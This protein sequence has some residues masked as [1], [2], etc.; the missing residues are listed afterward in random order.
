MNGD[1]DLGEDITMKGD[2]FHFAQNIQLSAEPEAAAAVKAD[3]PPPEKVHTLDPKIAKAHT[4][5]YNAKSLVGV[6]Q[7]LRTAFYAQYDRQN[8]LWR[9]DDAL[10]ATESADVP[11]IHPYNYNPWVYKF[12][13]DAMGPHS[14]HI[15]DDPEDSR[16]KSKEELA[17]SPEAIAKAEKAAAEEKKLKDDKIGMKN[18]AEAKQTAEQEKK[19]DAE[20]LEGA[21][22]KADIAE[23][24]EKVSKKEEKKAEL[25]MTNY[26]DKFYNA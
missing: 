17:N 13:R 1:E 9:T 22:K 4:T 10:V 23:E 11:Q 7:D 5:F 25:L 14:Q 18:A 26:N 6:E 21:L 19:A 20:A 16:P 8:H 15:D 12:S 3:Y 24:M 2:K